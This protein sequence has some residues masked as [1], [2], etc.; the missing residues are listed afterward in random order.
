MQQLSVLRG[1][2]D[3]PDIEWT[4]IAQQADIDLSRGF[5][6]F[7]EYLE[8]G[9]SALLTIRSAGR[10]RAALHGVMSAPES[11][12]TSDPWKFLTAEAVLRLRDDEDESEALRLR[13]QQREL[14][15]AAAGERADRD[16]PPW[17]LLT[18]GIGPCLVVREFDRSELLFHPG[19]SP[20][21]TESLA[22]QLVHGAQKMV[23]DNGAGAVT[24]P[25][26][27]PRDGLLRQVLAEAGFRGG[28]MTGACWI[29][30]TGCGSYQEFLAR[31]PTRR[32]RRYRLEEQE[33]R[34]AAGLR[35]G[36]VDLLENAERVA[37]LEAQTMIKYGGQPDP[38]DIR[39]ARV[40]LAGML[41][42]AVRICAVERDGEII[43][44]AMHVLGP[45]S[46][47]CLTYGADYGVAD[48]SMSYPWA[49]FYQPVKMAIAVGA[50]ALRLGLEGF[51]AKTI[52][53]AVVEARELWVW[54][55][56]SAALG[57]LGDVL[58]LVGARN[59]EYLARFPAPRARDPG[60]T[61]H[62]LGAVQQP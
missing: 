27:S 54:T 58:D 35:A 43:A 40:A 26:V 28:A 44:C 61:P 39:R 6:Q 21:E 47:L 2:D 13:R 7:R 52:R 24:F 41:P 23:L 11:G 4:E 33:L 3:V 18:R 29:D 51:E 5:L 25:F 59:T 8:P 9:A 50:G 34:Q 22:Q 46:V 42:D 31:L 1:V 20:A 55:P 53:G 62:G 15:S 14:A 48:R 10:L 19:A 32:R 37:A 36:V 12:L 56:D 45:R 49:V 57:R 60:A 38:E 16:A 17:E 30:T